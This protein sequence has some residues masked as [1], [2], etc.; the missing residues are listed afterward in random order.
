MKL[1]LVIDMQEATVGENHAPMFAYDEGLLSRINDRIEDYDFD[2]VVY[3]RNLMKKNLLNRFAPVQVYDGTKEA[4][5]AQKLKVVSGHIY[6]KFS[7]NA[8][9]NPE[10]V[11]FVK[12]KNADEVELVGVDGGGCVALTAIGGVKEGLNAIVN[13]G[14][15]GTI[16]KKQRDKLEKKMK[17]MGVAFQ[18]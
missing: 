9:S 2:N 12:E 1:L 11:S 15:V 5:L 6:D 13:E 18:K 7:G 10:L 8:F 3:I 14:C 4:E 16:M 17:K